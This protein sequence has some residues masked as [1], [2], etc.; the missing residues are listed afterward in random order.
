[1]NLVGMNPARDIEQVCD[2]LWAC[3]GRARSSESRIVQ[4]R[5]WPVPGGLWQSGRGSQVR[6]TVSGRAKIGGWKE[7]LGPACPPVQ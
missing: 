7:L 2:V 3:P 1:M 6:I 4:A 5:E